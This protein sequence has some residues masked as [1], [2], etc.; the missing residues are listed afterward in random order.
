MF[1]NGELR[2]ATW[3][4][5]QN[6]RSRLIQRATQRKRFAAAKGTITASLLS[7]PIPYKA[8]LLKQMHI[9]GDKHQCTTD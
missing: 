8:F 1:G 6:K 2:K 3:V 4:G 7:L 9:E 5:A